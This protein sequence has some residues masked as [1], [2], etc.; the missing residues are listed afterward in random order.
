M[1][2]SFSNSKSTVVELLMREQLTV[3]LPV[4]FVLA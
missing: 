4:A 2:S 1:V 3:G